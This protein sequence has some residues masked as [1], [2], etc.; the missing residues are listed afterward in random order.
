[1]GIT[2]RKCDIE[3]MNAKKCDRCGKYYE[4]W[5]NCEIHNAPFDKIKLLKGIDRVCD[6]DLCPECVDGLAEWLKNGKV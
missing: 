2:E 6:L 1:M 3:R 5:Y 4:A